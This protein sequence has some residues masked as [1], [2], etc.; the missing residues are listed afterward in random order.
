MNLGFEINL[1]LLFQKLGTWLVAPM[2]FF[3]FLG[4]EEFY[5]LIA[6]ALYWCFN[7]A[8]GLRL[9]LYLILSANLNAALKFLFHTPR[10]Y[11]IDLRVRAFTAESSFGIPSGH[12]QNAVPVWGTLAIHFRKVWIWV[13]AIGLMGLIGLSRVYL[14]VHFP[15]D[16]LVGWL[17]GAVLLGLMLS[18]EKPALDW[19]KTRSLWTQISSILAV[20][21]LLLAFGGGARLALAGW[22]LPQEW[23]NNARIAF[24]DAKPIDPLAFSSAVSNAGVF[25]GLALGGLFMF[26]RG[27]FNPLGPL[28]MRFSR[29]LLGLLGVLIL[30]MG[31]GE[32]LPRGETWLPFT[33]RFVRYAL[34]GLWV[35]YLAPLTFIRLRLTERE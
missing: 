9:G 35:T 28:G 13:G 12:A 1:I 26:R 14:G 31:L 34:T 16:V 24:P 10:P 33:L 27:W 21:F 23:I 2:R 18:L 7:T 3:T 17:I 29:Y 32:I 20:T 11:W 8:L 25:F 6:P 4:Y 5:L 15:R 30:W 19:L 22:T